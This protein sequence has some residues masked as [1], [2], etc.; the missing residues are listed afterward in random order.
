MK[1]QD[2][3]YLVSSVFIS[4]GGASAVIIGLS[5]WLGKVWAMKILE[6]DKSKYQKELEQLK[7]EMNIEISRIGNIAGKKLFIHTVQFKKEFEIYEELWAKLVE[8]RIST[9]SLRPILDAY[10]RNE[11]EE[12][13]KK[14]RINDFIEK[15]NDFSIVVEKNRPF[16]P[17]DTYK[18][19]KEIAQVARREQI[20]YR[21]MKGEIG[22]YEKAESNI[23]I[24]LDKSDE[25][26]ESIR[27][28]IDSVY[29][30]N[31]T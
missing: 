7:H 23:K 14:R 21:F 1:L 3:F 15:F 9:Q 25:V 26:C 24:I 31:N 10:D 19:I 8:L 5:S 13:R 12:D 30:I 4:I 20:E 28:R 17:E 16:Y 29:V 6:K 27:R 11:S 22:D 18:I 2:V